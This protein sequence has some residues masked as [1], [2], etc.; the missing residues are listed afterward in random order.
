MDFDP[1]IDAPEAGTS[2][3]MSADEIENDE[4][5]GEIFIDSPNPASVSSLNLESHWVLTSCNEGSDGPQQV[6][7]HIHD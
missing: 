2:S 4:A 6:C 3:N 7:D 1:D 5:F